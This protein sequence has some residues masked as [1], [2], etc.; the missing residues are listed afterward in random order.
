MRI[1]N[2][3][4]EIALT[5]LLHSR[6]RFD[7]LGQSF[8]TITLT[9]DGFL[10][11]FKFSVTVRLKDKTQAMF[12]ASPCSHCIIAIQYHQLAFR[13]FEYIFNFAFDISGY[14]KL[15]YYDIIWIEKIIGK[16]V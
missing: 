7:L 9:I 11:F 13:V 2:W 15:E 4:L 3:F 6:E 5:S 1:G 12:F 16:Q 10:I 8:A 14:F